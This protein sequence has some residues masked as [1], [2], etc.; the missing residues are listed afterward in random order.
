MVRGVWA[1]RSRGLAPTPDGG[2][3]LTM[4]LA[5]R[6]NMLIVRGVAWVAIVLL[7]TQL[8][9]CNTVEGAGKDIER[10]GEKLQK[11]AD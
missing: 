5:M 3:T 7:S 10:G 9:A 4:E 11:A 8:V 1:H 2:M 6:R